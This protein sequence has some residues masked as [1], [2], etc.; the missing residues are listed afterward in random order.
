MIVNVLAP[1]TLSVFVILVQIQKYSNSSRY[2]IDMDCNNMFRKVSI[3]KMRS[4]WSMRKLILA[5]FMYV[6]VLLL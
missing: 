3:G 6:D 2:G 5:L 4:R 1:H